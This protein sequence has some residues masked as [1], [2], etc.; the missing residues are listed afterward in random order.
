M[1][2]LYH[3]L[4]E[5]NREVWKKEDLVSY[6]L[7]VCANGTAYMGE[8]DEA[9]ADDRR[10]FLEEYP[11]YASLSFE[12]LKD[13]P[14]DKKKEIKEWYFSNWSNL[15]IVAAEDDE[16][17]DCGCPTQGLWDALY[18]VIYDEIRPASSMY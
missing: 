2:K 6:A 9:Y 11:E 17:E 3:Y 12:E 7:W 5:E 16:L 18:G 14:S 13:L 10:Q 8:E 4:S 15:E 1:A